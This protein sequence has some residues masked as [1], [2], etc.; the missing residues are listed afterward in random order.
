MNEDVW[1]AKLAS[2]RGIANRC[3]YSDVVSCAIGF[4]A[5]E[6]RVFMDFS[7][8]LQCPDSRG[9]DSSDIPRTVHLP[10]LLLTEGGL[11]IA[12]VT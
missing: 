1:K 7:E 4:M 9:Y 12:L 2:I 3:V 8:N 5:S 10:L 6:L 11:F